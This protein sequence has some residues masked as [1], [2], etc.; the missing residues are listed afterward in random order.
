MSS[1][2][3]DST[4]IAIVLVLF[5][6]AL[7]FIQMAKAIAVAGVFR[8]HRIDLSGGITPDMPHKENLTYGIFPLALAGILALTNYLNITPFDDLDA[9]FLRAIVDP[10]WLLKYSVFT[11]FVTLA[12]ILTGLLMTM[13]FKPTM[14]FM[15]IQV[16]NPSTEPEPEKRDRRVERRAKRTKR[17]RRKSL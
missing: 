10:L 13:A 15:G 7:I 11:A 12:G 16:A 5:G 3:L 9:D 2:N 6:P 17:T 4:L 1:I 14:G 8:W